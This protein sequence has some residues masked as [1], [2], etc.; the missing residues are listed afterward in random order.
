MP[1]LPRHNFMDWPKDAA[2]VT[3]AQV[4]MAYNAG[5]A[6]AK[7]ATENVLAE[8]RAKSL[9][10][11]GV[12]AA[13]QFGLADTGAGKLVAPFV[14]VL[15][16]FPN[17]WPGRQGQGRGDCVS[18]STRNA[19]LLTM[20]CDIVAGQPDI[21]TGQP[22][23]APEVPQAGI[24]DGVLSTEAFYWYRG[25]DGDG[26]MCHDAATVACNEAGLVPRKAYPD[27]G[28]DLTAYSSR[29]AGRW[30]RTPPPA[31]VGDVA[32]DHLAH[33][34]TEITGSFE[35]IRDYLYNGYGCSSCGGEGL[36]DQRDQNGAS[37][38]SGNWAHAMGYI[39]ADDRDVIKQL[40]SEPLVLDLNSWAKWNSGPRDIYQSAAL[41]P[42]SKKQLW[43]E[44]GIVNPQT[45]NIMIPEGSCWVRWSEWK[46]REVLAF[47]GVNGYPARNVDPWKAWLW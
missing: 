13:H 7:K 33:Q 29:T 47:S 6:G 38:R 20:A 19:I 9:Y 39:A 41:V 4:I 37:R 2:D 40:Y 27:L 32:N 36:S 31:N 16:M 10:P 8:W 46:H 14:H 24:E 22:E 30:G 34:S 17:C 42:G 35:S 1:W 5:F 18:W 43:I 25:Y 21:R 15:E 26:W 3:T 12:A 28:L 11:D 23:E 44:R 45:G